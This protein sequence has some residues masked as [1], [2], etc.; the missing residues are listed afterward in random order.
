MLARF[1]LIVKDMT[2][3][4]ERK[5]KKNLSALRCIKE[6]GKYIY[7]STGLYKTQT[8]ASYQPKEGTTYSK[9]GKNRKK[10]ENN[11]RP[12]YKKTTLYL[13]S[14][15]S[16]TPFPPTHLHICTQDKQR[17]TIETH[18]SERSHHTAPMGDGK[19]APNGRKTK[20]LRDD[21]LNA[22]CHQNPHLRHPHPSP[23]LGSP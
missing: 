3:P 13:S 4:T 21:L 11:T 23:R 2:G 7:W 9:K 17:Q 18:K 19:A 8:K 12:S 22:R 14:L 16:S 5:G 20:C 15:H 1:A 6:N 10:E